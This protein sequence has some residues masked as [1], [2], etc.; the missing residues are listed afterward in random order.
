MNNTQIGLAVGISVLV[1]LLFLPTPYDLIGVSVYMFLLS[2]A[3]Y[4]GLKRGW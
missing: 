4:V 3:L 2:V 1:G